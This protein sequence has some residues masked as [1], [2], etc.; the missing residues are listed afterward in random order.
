M[1]PHSRLDG[2][3]ASLL[4]TLRHLGLTLLRL[5][6]RRYLRLT[7]RAIERTV[8]ARL[9]H[10]VRQLARAGNAREQHGAGHGRQRR[11]RLLARGLARQIRDEV[12]DHLDHLVELARKGL[13]R[14]RSLSGDLGAE[15]RDRAAVTVVV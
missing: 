5:L 6:R 13:S 14:L 2:G 1:S 11:D 3:H 10:L 9:Q 7:P 12:R 4:P 15:R 8:L